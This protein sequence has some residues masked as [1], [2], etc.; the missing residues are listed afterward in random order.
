MCETYLRYACDTT[1]SHVRRQQAV[2]ESVTQRQ[3]ADVLEQTL[4]SS[5]ETVASLQTQVSFDA[6]V[7]FLQHVYMSILTHL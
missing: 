5:K 4:A 3:R 6:F 7:G 1:H 2:A